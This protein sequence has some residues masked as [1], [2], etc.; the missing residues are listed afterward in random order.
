MFYTRYTTL[1]LTDSKFEDDIAARHASEVMVLVI[2]FVLFCNDF[3]QLVSRHSFICKVMR[4][5]C[6]VCC[7]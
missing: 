6:I 3:Y 5:L 2:F 1:P 7:F 4:S